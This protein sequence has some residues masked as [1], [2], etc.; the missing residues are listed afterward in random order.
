[1]DWV[2]LLSPTRQGKAS[3][4]PAP[5][6]TPDRTPF[7]VDSDRLIFSSAFRRLHDK[8]Q[9]FPF[10]EDDLVHSRLT[11]SL[12]VACVGRSLGT[13]VGQRIVAEGRAPAWANNA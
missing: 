2:S 4:S 7:Q 13:R 8:T 12:E 6:F 10:P 3:S 1:M 5:S 11:H 9:V